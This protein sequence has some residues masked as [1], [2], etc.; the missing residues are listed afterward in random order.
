MPVGVPLYLSVDVPALA[1]LASARVAQNLEVQLW[2]QDSFRG[3]RLEGTWGDSQ[4][5]F[6]SVWTVDEGALM[7]G[8]VEASPAELARWTVRWLQRQ[9]VRPLRIRAWANG[10]SRVE[11]AD[12]GDALGG[13]GHLWQ[14]RGAPLTDTVVRADQGEPPI[15]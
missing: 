14:R 5:P 6:D 11:L 2:P 10:A 7:V 15:R 1:P 3:L 12:S 8:G 13:A 9:L 4:Y